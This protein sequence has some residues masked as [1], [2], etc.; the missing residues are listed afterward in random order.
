MRETQAADEHVL[1]S[2]PSRARILDLVRSAAEPLTAAD[3]ARELDIHV[4]TVRFHLDQLEQAD[5]VL[6]APVPSGGRGRPRIGY[7]AGALD[8]GQVREQMIDALAEALADRG[9]RDRSLAAGRRWADRLPEPQ[10]E[11]AAAVTEVFAQLGFAPDRDGSTIDLHRCPFGDAARRTPEVVCR[12]HL[13]LAQ[14]LA[15]RAARAQTSAAPRVGLVPFAGPDLCVL[16]IDGP[17]A[18]TSVDTEGRPA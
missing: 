14:G 1:L 11:P 18:D 10:G 4:T 3:L 13:G 7:R 15:T 9:S 5:L 17:G 8:L 6:K 2:V 12:V 16:T